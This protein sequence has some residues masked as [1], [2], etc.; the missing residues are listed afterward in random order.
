MFDLDTWQEIFESIRKHPLRSILTAFGVA[1]G[2]FMLVFLLGS[3]KG[4]QNGVEYQFRDDAL[5]SIWVYRGRTSIAHKGLPEGRRIQFTNQDYNKLI[6]EFSEIEHITG[7]FYIAGERIVKYRDEALSFNV[8]SVHPGHRY[9]ENTIM[10]DGRYLNEEDLDQ[11]RKVAVIGEIVVERLFKDEDPIGKFIT[12]NDVSYKVVG[13]YRDTGGENEMRNIYIPIT[14]GQKVYGG[15]EDIHQLMFT[16]GDLDLEQSKEL[17]E[18]VRVLMSQIHGFNP[19][20]RR[21]LYVNNNAENYEEFQNLFGM[22]RAFV[23]FIGIGSIIAGV[24]GVSNIMLIIVKDRTKEIG[25]RKAMGATPRSIVSMIL[26]ES[27]FITSLAGYIG[28]IFGVLVLYALQAIEID[29]FRQPQVNIWVA[30][31]ALIVLVVCGALAGLIPAMQAAN[32][33]PIKAMKDE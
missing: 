31:Q 17:S 19:A 22:I 20:D 18:E 33:N 24:I 4:L 23:L 9:I 13:R 3:G 26:Q 30:V 7:R 27:I 12:I 29:Y 32:V 14:T 1:W 28:M 5:N 2:I 8:R 21:A 15:S 11:F 16:I 6:E 10:T 25:I